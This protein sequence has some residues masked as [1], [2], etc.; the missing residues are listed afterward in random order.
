M[1]EVT[2]EETELL[3][4]EYS[5]KLAAQE[6]ENRQKLLV[7]DSAKQKLISLGFS[8]NEIAAIMGEEMLDHGSGMV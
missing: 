5:K 2:D 3:T 7:R 6:E 8:P 1:K 4:I